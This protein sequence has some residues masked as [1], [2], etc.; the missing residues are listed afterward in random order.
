M[1]AL[2]SSMSR[3]DEHR[4]ATFGALGVVTA[5]SLLHLLRSHDLQHLA[6]LHW[7]RA[8]IAGIVNVR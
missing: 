1:V 3:W 5:E 2:A 8:R 7:L 4:S 6:G